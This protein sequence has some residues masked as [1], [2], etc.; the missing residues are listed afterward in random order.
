MKMGFQETMREEITGK[1]ITALENGTSPW[2]KPWVGG[3]LPENLVSKKQYRG[4]NTLLLAIHQMNHK[5]TS[6]V[7]ATF[8]QW[9]DAGCMVKKRPAD[10]PKDAEYGAKIIFFSPIKGEKTQANGEK[11]EYSFP[12]MRGFTV[13]NADQVEGADKLL[14]K[15]NPPMPVNPAEIHDKAET[16]IQAY[17]EKEGLKIAVSNHAAYSPTTDMLMMP[18]RENFVLGTNSYYGTLFHELVHSTNH[19]TRLIRSEKFEKFGTEAYAME[20]LVAE[21]GGCY[22]QG[23][24]GLPI[25]D[26]LEN[27]ASYLENWLKVLKKDHKAIFSAAAAASAAADYILKASQVEIEEVEEEEAIA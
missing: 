7:Y 8:N 27:H 5:L 6:N 20:E 14:A 12:I 23:S 15:R 9:K 17:L 19:H 16:I 4:I 11:K 13:F 25:L 18:P 10:L 2:R 21:I 26:T 22:L 1:I 3:G 24:S